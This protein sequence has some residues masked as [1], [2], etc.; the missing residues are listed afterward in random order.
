MSIV[1]LGRVLEARLKTLD[2]NM[3]E[4]LEGQN[5][6]DNSGFNIDWAGLAL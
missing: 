3:A 6:Y 5:R 4:E 1:L 2:T